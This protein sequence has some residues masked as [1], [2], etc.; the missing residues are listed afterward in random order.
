MKQSIDIDDTSELPPL[1]PKIYISNIIIKPLKR[2]RPEPTIPFNR[3]QPFFNPASEP[4]LEL[5]NIVVGISLK[6]LK[7]MK[8]KAFVFP[9]DVEA[10]ARK[11]EENFRESLHLLVDHVKDNIKGRGMEV[12]RTVMDQA[13]HSNALRITNFNH[14]EKCKLQEEML[15]AVSESVRKSVEAA[16]RLAEEE[17]EYARLISEAELKKLAEEEALKILVERAVRIAEVETQKLVEAQEMGPQQG[18]DTI[19]MDQETNEPASDKGKDVV[20][21]TTPPSS[22]VRLITGSPSSAIPPA[23]Q[24]A[25]DEMKVEMKS[26]ISDLKSDISEM[27]TTMETKDNAAHEKMDKIMGFLKDIVK[28]L[29]KP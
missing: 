2:K 9:S 4:N 20:I 12:L 8:E 22:P 13:E 18:E 29:P 11:I 24:V 19:M 3:A 1:Y 27:K 6:R 16:K 7:N 28:R 21:D 17:A 15:A 14:E 23:V 26:D 10:E 5:L 25:L